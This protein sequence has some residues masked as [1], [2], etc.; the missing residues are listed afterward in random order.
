MTRRQS[1]ASL[2]EFARSF[3]DVA[4]ISTESGRYYASLVRYYTVYKLQRMPVRVARLYLLCFA[5]H[6]F[7]QINDNLIEAFIHL[8][9]QYEKWARAAAQ[10]AMLKAQSDAGSRLQAAGKLLGL[11]VDETI[12]DGTPF[13]KVRKQAFALL[14]R[15]QFE[16]VSGY[17]RNVAFDRA[18]FK[19]R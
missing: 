4:G 3:L 18:G 19:K 12:A 13:S 2:H 9:Q 5:F 14:E 11:F 17:L 16:P 15:E 8:V 6:R 7:R 10:E 1:F